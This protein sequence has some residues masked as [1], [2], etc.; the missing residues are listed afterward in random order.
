[1]ADHRALT[2]LERLETE[3]WWPQT[4]RP[5]AGHAAGKVSAEML[6]ADTT[7]PFRELYRPGNRMVPLDQPAFRPVI[8]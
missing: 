6:H 3:T 1:M 7:W 2:H 5:V 8:L 4:E